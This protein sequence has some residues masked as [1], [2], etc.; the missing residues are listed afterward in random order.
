MKRT[1]TLEPFQ[2]CCLPAELHKG[3]LAQFTP[4]EQQ[5]AIDVHVF[6]AAIGSPTGRMKVTEID[7]SIR[8][9]GPALA[10]HAG[11]SSASSLFWSIQ[12]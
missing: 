7:P 1:L 4:T 9:I 11:S 10:T 2:D 5:A 8:Y 6:D 3:G 12:E